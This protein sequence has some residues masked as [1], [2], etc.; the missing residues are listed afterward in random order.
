[1]A[2]RPKRP[3]SYDLRAQDR[4]RNRLIQL[5]LTGLVI[6]FAATVVWFVIP[7][8]N[9]GAVLSGSDDTAIRVT[10][11]KLVTNAGTKDPKA[12]L[13]LY[14]DF[15][16]PACANFERQFGQTVSNL[17][18]MGAIAADYHM[19]AILDRPQN[20]NYSSRAG[21]AG[22]CV[23]A[24]SIDAFRRF[25]TAMYSPQIQ[26]SETDTTFPDNNRLI[27]LARQAGAAGTV[28]ACVTSGKYLT[29]VSGMAA[30]TKVTS[31]PTIR[32][33][34]QDYNPTTPDD[35]VAKI[36]GIVGNVPGLDTATAPAAS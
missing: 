34:G 25:H 16:C 6:I 28:P 36:K 23:A 24:E 13:S 31:T 21:N 20:Q 4:R 7:H 9:K 32:I 12:V 29:L 8:G 2:S 15:L 35:L 22:Y 26:P 10:S 5:G 33:N 1:V 3:A 19:V 17:I 27:E 30:A 11:S 14:E 18:D